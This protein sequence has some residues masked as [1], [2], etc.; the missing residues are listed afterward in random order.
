M[1]VGI[2]GFAFLKFTE[3][4][5]A[6]NTLSQALELTEG[7]EMVNYCLKALLICNLV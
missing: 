2:K 6:I 3:S 1:F 5:T 7:K 4:E